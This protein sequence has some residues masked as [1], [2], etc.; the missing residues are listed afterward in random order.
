M[1][2]FC[3]ITTN[4]CYFISILLFIII[5]KKN[6]KYCLMHVLAKEFGINGKTYSV[7]LLTCVDTASPDIFD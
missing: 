5:K 6:T 7:G 1:T 3:Q 4:K 2:V